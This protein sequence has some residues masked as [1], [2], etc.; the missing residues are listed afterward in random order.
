M[1]AIGVDYGAVRIGVAREVPGTN[2]VVPLAT[3]SPDEFSTNLKK[4]IIDFD[5]TEVFVG[6][7]KS[8]SGAAGKQAVSVKQ[9]A[10]EQANQFG[11]TSWF[12]ID[13]RMTSVMAGRALADMGISSRDQ[14]NIVDEYA[15]VLILEQALS[16][17]KE[18]GVSNF[19]VIK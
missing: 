16:I 12:W 19:E 7:P 1:T 5:I 8:L 9:W 13:E 15:A 2:L 4:W 3:L 17:R 10:Q 18:S 11:S 14:R 6:L